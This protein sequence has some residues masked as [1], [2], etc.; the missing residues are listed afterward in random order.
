MDVR[1]AIE[2]RRARRSL[3]PVAIEKDTIEE[4]ARCASLSA[5]CF[6]NQPWRYEF[7]AGGEKLE[8]M[9]DALSKGNAWAKKASMI[10]AVHA[11]AGDDCV[12]AGREYYLFDTGMATAHIILRAVELGLVAHPIAGFDEEKV[13]AAFGLGSEE[14]VI[15]LVIVGKLAD[16]ID[17]DLSPGQKEAEE[18]RPERLPLEKFARI[19]Y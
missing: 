4:L 3:A 2:T 5:S 18:M 15:T 19:Y 11:K 9:F 13:K 14:T 10:I 12:V 1:E 8:K 7:A 17:P 6:N 16:G